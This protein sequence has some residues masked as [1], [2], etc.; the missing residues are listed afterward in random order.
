M[1][2]LLIALAQVAAIQSG[3]CQ[4]YSS[5]RVEMNLFYSCSFKH[6]DN[7]MEFHIVSNVAGYTSHT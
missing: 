6:F 5:S 1:M 4:N 7:A 2:I 3:M